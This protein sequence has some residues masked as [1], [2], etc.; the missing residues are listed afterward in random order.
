MANW[1]IAE[2]QQ[3]FSKLVRAAKREPQS[4][5]N[6]GRLVA[7]VIDA[8]VYEEFEAWRRTRKRRSLGDA[9][10]QLRTLV[11]KELHP[12]ET[13]PRRDRLNRFID[14]VDSAL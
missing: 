3:N 10:A 1:R 9:F 4:I 7:V 8:A 5:H 13:L 2:A 12:L 6:R 14:V 11:K